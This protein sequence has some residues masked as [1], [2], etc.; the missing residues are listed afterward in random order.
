MANRRTCV[1]LQP[2]YLPWL[3]FFEQ[4]QRADEFVYLDDVQFDKHG[5]RNRN[6]IKG[7]GGP[8]WLTVPVRVAGL[9]QPLIHDVEIDATQARW[10][11][12]HVQAL[13]TNYGPCPFFDWLMPDLEALLMQPWT[14]IADLD[15]AVAGR[16]CEKLGL[17]RQTH[18]SSALGATGGRCT[19][20][21]EICR[22][23]ACDHYYS[24]AAARDYM[25]VPAFEQAGITV[26]FQDYVHPTYS[27]RYGPFVSHLSIVDLLFNCG[28]RSLEILGQGVTSHTATE[29]RTT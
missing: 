18:R 2:G 8:Q 26:H 15:I 10:A 5:W 3:G 6:R 17:T 7:P 16:L 29:V 4:M 11:T 13:K 27:Q 14:H 20:L 9:N 24:G 28:P 12:R 23:L 25:D 21:I 1:V 22:K 19:R